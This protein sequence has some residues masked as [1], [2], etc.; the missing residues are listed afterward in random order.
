[1]TL[2]TPLHNAGIEYIRTHR[3]GKYDCTDMLNAFMRGGHWTQEELQETCR[4][5]LQ[6]MPTCKS[7][8]K[9]SLY[10]YT[11]LKK[12]EEQIEQKL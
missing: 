10:W 5:L 1:M 11:Q 2:M 7:E 8:E 12:L 3:K 9:L 6:N 4:K